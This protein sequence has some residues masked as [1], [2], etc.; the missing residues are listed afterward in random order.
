M[1]ILVID[2]DEELCCDIKQ[3]LG[4][5]GHV[6]ECVHDG[7]SGVHFAGVADFDLVI[8]DLS[9]PDKDGLEV[10]RT[11][12]RQ[13]LN[14]PVLMLTGRKEIDD[15]VTGLNS[16]ADDYLGKPFE[17]KELLARIQ[18]L[19]RRLTG[20]RSPEIAVGDVSVDTTCHQVNLNGREIALTATEYR[21][22]EY[23]IT[24]PNKLITRLE[25][26]D[27][28]RGTDCNYESNVIDSHIAKLRLKLAWDARTG[29]LQTVRGEGYRLRS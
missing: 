28:I 11:L 8:L 9:L 3:V 6:A 5:N 29:P 17:Y 1:R 16:G 18:A 7:A 10:C 12:R 23:F 27:R 20:N 25:M 13:G 26:E 2:D 22:L 24:N 19:N 4:E 15:R 21:I 14:I